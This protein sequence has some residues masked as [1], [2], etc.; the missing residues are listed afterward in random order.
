VLMIWLLCKP[1]HRLQIEN[2][3]FL[4]MGRSISTFLSHQSIMIGSL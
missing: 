2:D 4:Y 1:V 3:I